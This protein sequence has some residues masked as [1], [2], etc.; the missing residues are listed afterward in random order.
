MFLGEG[1]GMALLGLL[2]GV[3]GGAALAVV[4]IFLINRAYFGWTIALSVRG[5]RS[6]V[7]AAAILA[8]AVAVRASLPG[9]AGEPDSRLG[10]AL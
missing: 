8:A 9:A 2:L 7:Q 6:P 4:L 1:T 10:L 5:G 3:P